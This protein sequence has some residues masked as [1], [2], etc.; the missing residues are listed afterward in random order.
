MSVTVEPLTLTLRLG[1]RLVGTSTLQGFDVMDDE[2]PYTV[3]ER[4]NGLCLALS[5]A[6]NALTDEANSHAAEHIEYLKDGC[7]E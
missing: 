7:A 3:G 5:D 2:G 4:F 1:N 6:G